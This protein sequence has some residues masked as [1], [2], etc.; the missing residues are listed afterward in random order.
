MKPLPIPDAG[1]IGNSRLN[2]RTSIRPIQNA[3]DAAPNRQN[4]IDMLSKKLYCFFAA[5]T[6]IGIPTIIV[7]STAVPAS[8]I[9]FGSLAAI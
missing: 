9:V 5:N 6:P 1:R 4:T 7:S 3:G 2:T 8:N